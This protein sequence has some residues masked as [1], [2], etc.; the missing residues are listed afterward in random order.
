MGRTDRITLQPIQA[1]SVPSFALVWLLTVVGATIVFPVISVLWVNYYKTEDPA[2]IDLLYRQKQVALDR[3]ASNAHRLIIIGGSGTL[4]GV[5]AELIERKLHIPTVNFATHAGLGL[6]YLLDRARG[7]LRQGDIVLVSA[8]YGAWSDAYRDSEGPAFD[9]IWTYDKRYI[10]RMNP[11]EVG[12][13]VCAIPWSQW[14]LSAQGWLDRI[15]GDY[16]HFRELSMYSVATL[17]VAG[18]IRV[19]TPPGTPQ[20]AA[21][22]FP[23]DAALPATESIRQFGSYARSM[24]IGLFWSWPDFVRP[25]TTGRPPAFMSLVLQNSGFV[26]LDE[27]S[28]NAFPRDWFMDTPY[29]ANPCCRRIRTEELIR[30]LR[31]RLGLPPAPEKISGVFLVA[32]IDHQLTAGNLFADDPGVVVRY[33]RPHDEMD[34]RALSPTAVAN[35]V[36]AGVPVYSDA[37]AATPLLASAGLG[38]QLQSSETQSVSRWFSRY[39]SNLFCIAAPPGH[40]LDPA[41]KD[42]VP[43]PIYQQLAATHASVEIFGTGPYAGVIL[44]ATD[45][46]QQRLEKLL[47]RTNVLPAVISLR[48]D[49]S[50]AVDCREFVS[51][52]TGVCVVVIDPE[53]GTVIDTAV[54][55]P[56]PDIQTWH[57]YRVAADRTAP[58]RA[59]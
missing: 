50:I 2:W 43:A 12:K 4:F 32:G 55:G 14:P 37:D 29:H 35:L 28:D 27:P 42:A 47:W 58:G 17:D 38:V 59:L 16:F 40:V 23:E 22:P 44:L 3:R 52:R 48:T 15:H 57:L 24:G 20:P 41:W 46:Y 45:N 34:V 19:V 18:D 21:F 39:Q 33:L 5:D 54:F 51:S 11:I 49:A 25:I 10:A 13:M 56:G 26:V 30:R 7:E 36:R 1:T 8:E 9:Y 53:M 6:R 31:P